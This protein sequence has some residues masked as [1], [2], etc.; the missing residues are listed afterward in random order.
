VE[1]RAAMDYAPPRN[2]VELDNLPDAVVENFP[3]VRAPVRPRGGALGLDLSMLAAQRRGTGPMAQI[4]R[5][6]A[7]AWISVL[8]MVHQVL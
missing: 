8:A 2:T 7:F 3:G 5:L 6:G 1:F 4:R